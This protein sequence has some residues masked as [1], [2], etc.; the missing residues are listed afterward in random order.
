[1]RVDKREV[2][3]IDA[4]K[5]IDDLKAMSTQ[6]DAIAID[7]M[8]QGIERQS[9]IDA[10]PVVRCKGCKYSAELVNGE[11]N[12]LHCGYWN[13]FPVKDGYCYRGRK[14]WGVKWKRAAS[15]QMM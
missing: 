2:R 14:G 15:T 4:N 13:T 1:M 11:K 5:I 9:T 3:P 6:Y 12:V 7:G 10:V 8:I